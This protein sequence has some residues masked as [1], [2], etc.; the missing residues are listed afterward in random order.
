MAFL[1]YHFW[2]QLLLFFTGASWLLQGVLFKGFWEINKWWV[3]CAKITEERFV[4]SMFALEVSVD[5]VVCWKKRS[6]YV[7]FISHD[8]CEWMTKLGNIFRDWWVQ[9]SAAFFNTHFLNNIGLSVSK[10][11]LEYSAVLWFIHIAL[12]FCIWFCCTVAGT[13]Y[14]HWLTLKLAV[15]AIFFHGV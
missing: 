5:A 13:W 15:V 14:V 1:T 4:T 11:F 7:F 2:H 8:Y 9:V 6:N 12:T 3:T 10:Q